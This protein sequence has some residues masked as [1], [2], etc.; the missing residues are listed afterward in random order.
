[1]NKDIYNRLCYL[2]GRNYFCFCQVFCAIIC[3]IYIAMKAFDEKYL[4]NSYFWC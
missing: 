1:M 3:E 2:H 4:K